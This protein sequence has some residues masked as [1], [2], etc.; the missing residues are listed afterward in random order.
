M[1]FEQFRNLLN[2]RGED[3]ERHGLRTRLSRHI[4]AELAWFTLRSYIKGFLVHEKGEDRWL[5]PH[6]YEEADVLSRDDR[7]VS[8]EVYEEV[9]E[10]VWPWYKRLTIP[11][12][13]NDFC[14][15]FWDDLDLAW[16]VLDHR[17][18]NAGDYAIIVCDEAQDLSRVESAALFSSLA[19]EKYDLSTLTQP[20]SEY[21]RTP[22]ILT[23]DA[24]QTVSPS[25][26]RWERVKADCGR[27][28]V[29][30][31]PDLPLPRVKQYKLCF[32]YR[33]AAT[34][35]G[36]C[37]G[38]QLLREESLGQ[39]SPLQQ[40]WRPSSAAAS[41]PVRRLLVH[42]PETIEQLLQHEII[43]LGPEPADPENEIACEFW[44]ALGLKN[45]CSS[46]YL[47][48]TDVKG[49]EADIVALIG[50]GTL[51]GLLDLDGIWEWN[52]KSLSEINEARKFT[53]AY[54]LNRLYVA[55][56]GA[57][58][59]LWIVE[60]KEGWKAFWEKFAKY[61][62]SHHLQAEVAFKWRDGSSEGLIQI[63]KKNWPYLAKH[64][65]ELAIQNADPRYAELAAAN[66][67]RAGDQNGRIRMEAYRWYF[68]GQIGK[69]AHEM[70]E[71]DRLKASDWL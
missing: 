63:S 57:R 40:V 69:A 13:S 30:H 71:V 61:I 8:S 68:E 10:K 45:V 70:K 38:L 52:R 12:E 37:N 31:L 39:P 20:S 18:P 11:G 66:Y 29:Q 9:W 64:F 16:Q 21:L 49:L 47:T 33:N 41:E 50:F 46:N 5:S 54:F 55:A 48:P 1:S 4:S 34:I 44:A 28:L 14:P 53:A 65:E 36:L 59:Q 25:C 56:S 58:E 24:H 19:W 22:V 35:A 2:G 43:V 15:P 67:K 26:F 7:Q 3:A 42:S 23:G 62:E 32:N 27:A 17:D 51:F 60:T 6:Q